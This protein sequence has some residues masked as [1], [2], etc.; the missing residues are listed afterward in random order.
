MKALIIRLNLQNI[1]VTTNDSQTAHD[2]NILIFYRK[3]LFG[4]IATTDLILHPFGI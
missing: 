4:A 2:K 1:I 3:N